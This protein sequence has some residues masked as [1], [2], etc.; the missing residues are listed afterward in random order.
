MNKKFSTVA[1]FLK[2]NFGYFRN[3]DNNRY[4]A[5]LEAYYKTLRD[6]I[7]YRED[8]VNDPAE[9]LENEFV[10]G[11]G[12]SYGLE[13]FLRKN[14]GILTGWIAYTLS[15]TERQFDDINNGEVYPT[16]FDRRHDISLVANYSPGEKWEV[17][18]EGSGG[19]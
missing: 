4:E 13:F 3:F 17:G 12:R 5:S 2:P 9:D 19:A 10:F 8:Y 11:E 6:Q 14:K 18:E 7:D 16:Q 15:R 1:L